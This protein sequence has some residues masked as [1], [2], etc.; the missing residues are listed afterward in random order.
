MLLGGGILC[1]LGAVFCITWGQYFVFLSG[2]T[3]L[4]FQV[5]DGVMD[6]G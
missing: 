1:Y 4:G 2:G 5:G 6:S 3:A